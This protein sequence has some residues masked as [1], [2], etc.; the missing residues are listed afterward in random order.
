MPEKKL[1]KLLY[2]CVSCAKNKL[3]IIFWTNIVDC[4]SFFS[5]IKIYKKSK[6]DEILTNIDVANSHLH[7]K[8]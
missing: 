4:K 6:D 7:G 5:N 1:Y 3:A 8:L 2:Y